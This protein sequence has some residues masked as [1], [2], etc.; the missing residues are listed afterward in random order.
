MGKQGCGVFASRACPGCVAWNQRKG[1]LFLI[2]TKAPHRLAGPWGKRFLSN[3]FLCYLSIFVN[4]QR[5][6]K[7]YLFSH[8]APYWGMRYRDFIFILQIFYV[9]DHFLTVIFRANKHSENKKSILE[10]RAWKSS[11]LTVNIAVLV[12]SACKEGAFLLLRGCALVKTALR[13][14]ESMWPSGLGNG[15]QFWVW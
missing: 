1:H 5:P 9:P 13:K 7:T 2:L 15:V 8:L 12:P 14:P 6:L 10:P 4:F 3:Q 11:Y